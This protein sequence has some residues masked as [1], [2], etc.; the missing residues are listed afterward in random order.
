MT[1]LDF[2]QL[3]RFIEIMKPFIEKY[4]VSYHDRIFETETT[5]HYC[6]YE[7]YQHLYENGTIKE[8]FEFALL[9]ADYGCVS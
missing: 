2:K 6:E 4:K 3:E 7:L 1:I 8:R 5:V 9:H